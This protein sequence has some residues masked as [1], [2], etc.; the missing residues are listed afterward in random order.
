MTEYYPLAE[1]PSLTNKKA[2]VRRKRRPAVPIEYM[3]G[4]YWCTGVLVYW[5]VVGGGPW[6]EDPLPLPSSFFLLPWYFL[7]CPCST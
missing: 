2:S 5:Y 3:Q 4:V 1:A 7:V 6:S